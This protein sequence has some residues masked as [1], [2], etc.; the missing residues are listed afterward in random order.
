[1]VPSIHYPIGWEE[2]AVSIASKEAYK[3]SK[4]QKE[5]RAVQIHEFLL[6]QGP[7]TWRGL[8]ALLP[9][10]LLEQGSI[11]STTTNMKKNG[12]V[13]VAKTDF[14]PEHGVPGRRYSWYEANRLADTSVTLKTKPKNDAETRAKRL[15]FLCEK[16]IR[17]FKELTDFKE[18]AAIV[19]GAEKQLANINTVDDTEV[20]EGTVGVDE[21]KTDAPTLSEMEMGLK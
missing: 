20:F 12:W 21:E 2:G 16:L 10:S 8:K 15:T 17:Q 18:I 13:T 11:T 1:M 5:R 6:K 3:D 9:S 14:D 7:L 19:K 4:D